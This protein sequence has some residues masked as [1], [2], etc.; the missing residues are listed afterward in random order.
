[1]NEFD[2]DFMGLALEEAKKALQEGLLP[3]GSVVVQ[4]G[5]VIGVGRRFKEGHPYLDHAEIVSLRTALGKNANGEMATLYTTLEPC[6]MCFSTI[7]N[8]RRI[9]RIVFAIEDPYGGGT[10]LPKSVLTPRYQEWW[11]VIE[12]S[13]RRDDALILLKS[14][15]SSTKDPYWSNP[16]NPLRKLGVSI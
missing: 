2:K 11:P 9:E 14:F 3:V 1:M 8:S 13:V 16:N 5:K 15:F 4:N 6:L 7:L 10:N 12:G